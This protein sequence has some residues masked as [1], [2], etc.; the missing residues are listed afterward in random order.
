MDG[1][2]KVDPAT[3]AILHVDIQTAFMGDH[4]YSGKVLLGGGLPVPGGEEIIF[5]ARHDSSFFPDFRR[6][7]SLDM[8]PLGHISFASSHP[9]F[10]P[11]DELNFDSLRAAYANVDVGAH[12]E[13]SI[14]LVAAYLESIPGEKQTLWPDHAL[15][16]SPETLLHPHLADMK[17]REILPKGLDRTCDSYSAVTDNSGRST[18]LAERMRKSGVQRVFLDGLA[19]THCVGWSALGFAKRGFTVFVIKDATR[20]VPIPGAEAFM[21]ADLAFAGVHIIQGLQLSR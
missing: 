7:A 4:K 5:P 19:Y 1:T 21:D 3:D 17:F 2:I 12:L 14:G 8:H 10:K 16:G 6:Y 20:S 13:F 9:G 11:Y 18:G 15:V